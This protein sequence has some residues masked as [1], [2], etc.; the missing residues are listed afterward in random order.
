LL[1]LSLLFFLSLFA[2]NLQ[3]QLFHARYGSLTRPVPVVGFLAIVVLNVFVLRHW[4]KRWSVARTLPHAELQ[5]RLSLFPRR[6][7]WLS[8]SALALLLIVL[9][10]GARQA[11]RI[12]EPAQIPPIQQPNAPSGYDVA[13]GGP[14]ANDNRVYRSIVTV[15]PGYVLTVAAVLCS[16]QVVL[17][18][19]PPNAAASLMAPD[20][21]AAV[22]GRLTWR[23]LGNTTFA[24]G[25]P[26]QIS[27]GVQQGP[28]N[29]DKSF[30][31]VPPEPVAVDWV[32]EPASI[33][34]PQNGHTKVLL[35]KGASANTGMGIQPLAEWAV[36][37]EARLDPIPAN[38]LRDVK[39]PVVGLG[40]NWLSSFENA[41]AAQEQ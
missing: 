2:R 38:F 30:H 10:A 29:T 1:D 8:A 21:P 19:D 11:S 7:L 22:Q 27:L 28:E 13:P 18:P 36:G 39:S 12:D 26:L 9:L 41:S 23:L 31:I 32:G 3:W 24:D 34:P 25:A 40:T 14:P 6:A 33:W 5:A 17:K 16:N 4:L 20:G 15:P 35:V 37:I